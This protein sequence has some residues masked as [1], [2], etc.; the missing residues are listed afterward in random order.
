MVRLS[1][2]NGF[3]FE[4][5]LLGYSDCLC[6]A[7]TNDLGIDCISILPKEAERDKRE[8][9]EREG[10]GERKEIGRKGAQVAMGSASLQLLGEVT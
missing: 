6:E 7:S 1:D 2:R 9:T 10:K 8:R 5:T 4:L 3:P